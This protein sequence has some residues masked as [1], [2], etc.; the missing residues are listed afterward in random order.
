MDK[1]VIAY[2]GRVDTSV[3]VHWLK[4]VKRMKV[5]AFAADLGQPQYLEIV[6][7]KAIRAGTETVH[8]VD[9]K[10]RFVRDFVFP[11]LRAAAVYENGYLLSSA[12]SRP[13]LAQE[14]VRL[15]QEEDCDFIAH[16]AR[17][18]GNDLVR[19]ERCVHALDSDIAILAPFHELSLKTPKDDIDYARRQGL[20]VDHLR[21][22]IYN[23]EQNLWGTNVQLPI[24]TGLE[25]A[26]PRDAY[27]LTVPTNEAPE[28][29]AEIDI[30]FERGLPT[31]LDG[32]QT[33]PVRLIETLNA[34]GG[35]HGIGR[36]DTI[37]D[38]ISY[39]KS[40]EVYEAPAAT[41]L[42]AGLRA[43]AETVLSKECRLF[44]ETAA[45]TYGRLVYE[46]LWFTEL[47]EALDAFFQR[48]HANS[49]GSVRMRLYKG[50][51]LVL[52]RQQ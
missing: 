41:I 23:V 42:Y 16:G 33:A 11:A 17:G 47:R 9:L 3:C 32:T 25:M 31:A 6:G 20:P 43:L 50:N 26:A 13:L 49:T 40:R 35:R 37:E 27:I 21:H 36:I 48:C 38:R 51:C 5:I 18:L 52:G 7:E 2:T 22:T 15:A 12:L 29:P 8:I 34:L 46:G 45:R 1:V 30:R 44:A 10:E 39:A 28:R 24:V 19:F 4:T 14:L